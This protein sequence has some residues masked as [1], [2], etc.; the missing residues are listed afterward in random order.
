[1]VRQQI[2][3]SE[4]VFMEGMGGSF[5]VKEKGPPEV[6]LQTTLEFAYETRL[7]RGQRLGVFVANFVSI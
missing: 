2:I 7:L 4:V 1:M 5:Y 3:N 6:E